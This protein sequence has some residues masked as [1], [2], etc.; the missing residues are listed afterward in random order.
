MNNAFTLDS[1]GNPPESM[2]NQARKVSLKWIWNYS[3]AD[4]VAHGTFLTSLIPDSLGFYQISKIAGTRNGDP[5]T[6]LQP[7]GTPIPGNEPFDVDNLISRKSP[8]LTSN[9]FGF[10]TSGGDF[11]NPFFASFLNPSSYF[12]VLTSGSEIISEIPVSFSATP[13]AVVFSKMA[14]GM[15]SAGERLTERNL[16]QDGLYEQLFGSSSFEDS[17]THGQLVQV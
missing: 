14:P 17:A 6:G 11:A 5:I 3:A 9:G 12:E 7:T 10:S 1:L 4:V 15:G 8:Q 13:V 2:T 16:S